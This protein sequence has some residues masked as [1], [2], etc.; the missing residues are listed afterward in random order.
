MVSRVSTYDA[1][2]RMIAGVYASAFGI[3]GFALV[4][5]PSICAH[6]SALYRNPGVRCIRF[7]A[8]K[9]LTRSVLRCPAANS[10]HLSNRGFATC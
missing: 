7:I 1:S 4:G 9:S 3:A 5:P 8:R 10:Y 6:V 2:H